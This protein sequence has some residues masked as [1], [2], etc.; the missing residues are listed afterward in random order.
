MLQRLRAQLT[1]VLPAHQDHIVSLPPA[2][3]VFLLS[4]YHVESNRI[5]TGVAAPALFSSWSLF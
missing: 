4:I 1:G 3:L 5:Q 2:V